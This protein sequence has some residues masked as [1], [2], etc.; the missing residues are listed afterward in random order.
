[1]SE[2][3]KLTKPARAAS[4]TSWTHQ[5]QKKIHSIFAPLSNTTFCAKLVK[6]HTILHPDFCKTCQNW[7][8]IFEPYQSRKGSHILTIP[9]PKF[10]SRNLPKHFTAISHHP[11]ARKFHDIS[12]QLPQ[13]KF[14]SQNLLSRYTAS[15]HH[16]KAQ[17]V[18]DIFAPFHGQSKLI[19]QSFPNGFTSSHTSIQIVCKSLKIRL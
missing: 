3:L 12:A 10:I 13:P 2:K 6:L 1:M 5:S 7:H 16:P 17:T 19:L 18:F 4:T 15:T 9:H 14:M 11:K 8:G